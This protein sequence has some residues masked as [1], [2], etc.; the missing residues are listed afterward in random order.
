MI[1]ITGANGLLGSHLLRKF[2]GEKI[3]VVAIKKP[4][5]TTT[6]LDDLTSVEWREADVL[7]TEALVKV[8]QGTTTL[9]HTAAQVSFNPRARN[10]IFE[11]NEGGTRNV[12]NACLALNINHLIHISS[13]AAIGRQKGFHHINEDSKWVSGDL[14]TDYAESKYL[15]ELEVWR[16]HEEGLNVSIINPS[17]ILAP[18]TQMKSSAQ[19][20]HYVMNEKLFYTDGQLNFVDVRDVVAMIWK[21][22]H[23]KIYGE[24][25]IA[26]GGHTTFKNLFSQIAQRL[27]KKAPSVKMPASLLAVLAT[28]EEMRCRITGKEPLITRQSTKL[29]KEFFYYSNEKAQ[30]KFNFQFHSLENTLD[31]CCKDYSDAYTTNI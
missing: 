2:S 11:V 1:A 10:K 9:I 21:I 27:N 19:L 6:H 13:V 31:W 29:A 3:P 26:N 18:P 22:H 28:M 17:V 16:G 12:V 8:L 4:E 14:N 24:R 7:D 5:S 15:A 30:R 20:F 23:E 25:F